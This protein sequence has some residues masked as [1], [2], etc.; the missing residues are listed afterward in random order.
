MKKFIVI[1]AIVVIV[2]AGAW[3]V[4]NKPAS[5]P[6][7]GPV[8]VGT[9]KPASKLNPGNAKYL[10]E[11]QLVSLENGKA[12]TV[13]PYGAAKQ[14]TEIWGTPVSG[15]MNS[16]GQADWAVILTQKT[17]NDPGVYYYAAIA[18]VDEAQGLI[19]GSNAVPIGDRIDVKDI[20]IVNDAVKINLSRLEN[21]RR[22]R[23]SGAHPAGHKKLHPRRRDV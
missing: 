4:F 3:L 6:K 22:R 20:A 23:G 1:L 8:A 12:E 15:D 19:V 7:P 9:D 14:T 18:L 5:A 21:Q 16:D 13:S 2:A 17:E 10:V 11:A